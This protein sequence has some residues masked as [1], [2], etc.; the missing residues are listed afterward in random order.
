MRHALLWL[1]GFVVLLFSVVATAQTAPPGVE[2]VPIPAGVRY[3]YA[4]ADTNQAAQSHLLKA[5]KEGNDPAVFGNRVIIGPR[6]WQRIREIPE[7]AKIPKGEVTFKIPIKIKDAPGTVREQNL[8][9]K[10]IQSEADSRTLYSALSSFAAGK[11]IRLRKLRAEEL[12]YYWSII[13]WDIEEPLFA[14]E[15]PAVTLLL[16]YVSKSKNVFFVDALGADAP[17]QAAS[18]KADDA[19]RKNKE[20]VAAAQAK[21]RAKQEAQ[22]LAALERE[23]EANRQRRDREKACVYK[24]VM[25]N[26][27]MKAC[28]I[29]R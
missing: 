11:E 13:S 21:T 4:D 9:G 20:A 10:L 18:V 14:L 5:F 16:Q 3:K 12:S 1:Q 22:Q 23:K 7:L 27:D 19:A 2:S 26:E 25:T 8:Q 17:A 29:S 15:T 28:G 6:L 24:A